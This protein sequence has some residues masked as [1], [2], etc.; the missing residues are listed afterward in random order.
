MKSGKFPEVSGNRVNKS[1][2]IRGLVVLIALCSFLC[3]FFPFKLEAE[4]CGEPA[5]NYFRLREMFYK[6]DTG[7]WGSKSYHKK[8]LK[9]FLVEMIDCNIQTDYDFLIDPRLFTES[10]DFSSDIVYNKWLYVHGELDPE[11]KEGDMPGYKE[12]LRERVIRKTLFAVAGKIRRFRIVES[13][14]GRSVHIYLSKL[15]LEPAQKKIL[16]K[17]GN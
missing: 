11:L 12:L 5:Q 9:R 16:P 2:Y 13:F 15:R 10:T 6:W 3:L 17:G 4:G 1:I 8:R 14:R 7:F